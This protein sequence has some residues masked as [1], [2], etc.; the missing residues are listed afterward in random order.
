MARNDE[1]FGLSIDVDARSVDDARNRIQTADVATYEFAQT[2]SHLSGETYELA[3]DV[4]IVDMA[5][6]ELARDV[7]KGTAA[8]EAS[9][10]AHD[11]L[12]KS[13]QGAKGGAANLGRSMLESG[14]IVQDFAQ[15]GIPG[16]LNNIE[17][18]TVALG[19]GAGMAGA[20]T[21]VGVVAH[22]AGPKLLE[23]GK[24]L[25]ETR[26]QIP[27]ATDALKRME[28]AIK[29]NE[30]ALE[31]LRENTR[32][33]NSELKEFQRL[34][35]ENAELEKRVA[36]EK[37]RR[38]TLDKYK[39]LT[40]D[41]E[42]DEASAFTAAIEQGGPGEQ[43]RVRN[44][45][46]KALARRAQFNVDAMRRAMQEKIRNGAST[47]EQ[48]K[49]AEELTA[50]QRQAAQDKTPLA[51]EYIAG[52]MRGNTTLINGIV[53][54][55]E[56]GYGARLGGF[57]ERLTEQRQKASNARMADQIAEAERIDRENTQAQEEAERTN[58]ANAKK[59]FEAENKQL[60]AQDAEAK[61]IQDE[62]ERAAAAQKQ[63]TH[64]EVTQQLRQ[65]DQFADRTGLNDQAALYMAMLAN[66]GVKGDALTERTHA[67]VS[68]QLQ[69][70]YGMSRD[71]ADDRANRITSKAREDNGARYETAYAQ[72]IAANA[73]VNEAS[74]Y[75]NQQI[76]MALAEANQRF[77][78][79]ASQLRAQGRAAS[80]MRVRN[81]PMFA[82]GGGE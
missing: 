67:A 20:L 51:N 47:D 40:S 52:A 16:I 15:G 80:S 3:D 70:A 6:E 17:G 53:D 37:E 58:A 73:S 35:S 44:E 62:K 71:E 66:Q 50:F 65:E 45:L 38:A 76:L 57:S 28:D 4:K 81:R 60:E 29:A 39:H 32:L 14:R 61:R 41:T 31:K 11:R 7:A 5:M 21:V 42:K 33:S 49:M 59:R 69:N 48:V 78:G 34:T 8:A 54:L 1:S 63:I 55:A 82:P 68:G 18:M 46:A 25:F 79:H 2:I 64:G 19:L 12:G 30:K 24:S 26:N 75:T 13:L 36:A 22:L 27:E 23:F 72:A 74:I 9:T 77:A 10:R 43:E 56:G